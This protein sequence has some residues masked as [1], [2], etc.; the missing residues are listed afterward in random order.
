MFKKSVIAILISLIYIS[1]YAQRLTP[2]DADSKISFVIKNMGIN[3]D[4]TLKGL[5]GKMVF[6]PKKPAGSVFDVT[7]EAN[8]IDTDNKKRD[9]HLKK[10]D[11]FDVD[12][13]PTI[14][15]KTTSVQAKGNS[16]Y[17]AKAIL[18]MHGVSKNIQF[19]FIAKPVS[20]GYNFT[21]EFSL[22]RKDYGVGGNS[23]TMGD[24]VSVKLDVTGKK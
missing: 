4:G 16:T 7:V 17:F 3:V 15:I 19:D 1:S 18:T 13:Y 9:E 10:K 23:M 14:S 24:N 22:N 8:T 6:D 5:R 11:F 21:A 20:G 12:K 2:S